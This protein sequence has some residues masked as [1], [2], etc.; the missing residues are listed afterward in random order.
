MKCEACNGTGY[1]DYI[2]PHTVCYDMRCR[3]CNGTGE[4]SELK[5]NQQEE[6][7]PCPFCGSEAELIHSE[8]FGSDSLSQYYSVA[9]T[10]KNCDMGKPDCFYDSGENNKKAIIK[11]WNTRHDA[12]KE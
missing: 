10:N 6:L 8:M 9:C 11:A 2:M 1:R 12:G 7:L 4:Q 5:C 3:S